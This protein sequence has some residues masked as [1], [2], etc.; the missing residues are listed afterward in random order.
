L[1]GL[2]ATYQSVSI[3][4]QPTA[5]AVG[6]GVVWKL[7]LYCTSDTQLPVIGLFFG[8]FLDFYIFRAIN[9]KKLIVNK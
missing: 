7:P 9:S 4:P 2:L 1:V 8:G 6:V 5:K 3:P